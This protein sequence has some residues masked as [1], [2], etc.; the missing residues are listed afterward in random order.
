MNSAI[1]ARALLPCYAWLHIIGFLEWSAWKSVIN[2]QSCGR[3][4]VL[5]LIGG[6]RRSLFVKDRAYNAPCLIWVRN[7]NCPNVNQSSV[8]RRVWSGSSKWLA[9]W[10]NRH[11]R[12][13][14]LVRGR[15]LHLGLDR[16][17]GC[18][19]CR[20]SVYDD[21]WAIREIVLQR[22]REGPEVV[23]LRYGKGLITRSI[24]NCSF[25]ALR[26]V[27]GRCTKHQLRKWTSRVVWHRS[28]QLQLL[29]S[30]RIGPSP[31]RGWL[32]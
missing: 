24:N 23:W 28:G 6:W 16:R 2:I 27:R 14:T 19:C 17:R 7:S 10:A 31:R 26:D 15:A 25:I 21:S 3:V 29:V 8:R 18:T 22:Y 1:C 20:Y 32:G 4:S 9:C 11:H 12:S 30:R 13:Y 5:H